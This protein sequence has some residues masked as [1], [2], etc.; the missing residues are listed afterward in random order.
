VVSEES[1]ILHNYQM[2]KFN[3]KHSILSKR[4]Q[5]DLIYFY[6]LKING[7]IFEVCAI[8]GCQHFIILNNKYHELYCFWRAFHLQLF[9]N[10][11]A[12]DFDDVLYFLNLRMISSYKTRSYYYI[13]QIQSQILLYLDVISTFDEKRIK[14]LNYIYIII[15]LY[16]CG[17]ASKF[18]PP[19]HRAPAKIITVYTINF[20]FANL[21]TLFDLLNNLVCLGSTTIGILQ[22]YTYSVKPYYYVL[23]LFDPGLLSKEICCKQTNI[24]ILYSTC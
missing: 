16:L 18:R 19:S 1:I 14:T 15:I 6:M 7:S 8:V 20:L 17:S 11:S 21:Y 4:K 13:K 23:V 5:K 2:I 3:K 10:T 22:L 24:S 12:F 9:I